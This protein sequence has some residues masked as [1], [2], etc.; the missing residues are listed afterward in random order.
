MWLGKF[1]RRPD[2][3]EIEKIDCCRKEYFHQYSRVSTGPDQAIYTRLTCNGKFS[4]GKPNP[5]S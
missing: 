2:E 5:T 3:K 1:V 4:E